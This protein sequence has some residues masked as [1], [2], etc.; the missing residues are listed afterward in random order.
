MSICDLR[1]S[2]NE[3]ILGPLFFLLFT[4]GFLLFVWGVV[5][6]LWGLNAGSKEEGKQNGKRHMLYGVIGLFV[7]FAAYGVVQLIVN[8]VDRDSLNKAL[9]CPEE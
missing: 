3:V 7:M 9:N 4:L 8:T 6:F 5:E 2:I 1:D